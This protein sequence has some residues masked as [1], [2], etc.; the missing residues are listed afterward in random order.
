MCVRILCI[1]FAVAALGSAFVTKSTSASYPSSALL[2]SR[3]NLLFSTGGAFAGLVLASPAYAEETVASMIEELES[4]KLKLKSVPGLIQA[5]NWEGVRQI[6]KSPPVNNLWNMGDSKNTL[7]KI[8]KAKDDFGLVEIKDELSI[9]LQICD[10]LVYDNVF[11][12]YQPG[13]GKV[14]VKEP[15][16]LAAKAIAQLGEAIEMAKSL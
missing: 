3:R 7:L 8:A 16:D 13:N 11:V 14:K 12:Y 4:S 2:A 6:L 9:S 1:L 5:E 15:A 10:Q